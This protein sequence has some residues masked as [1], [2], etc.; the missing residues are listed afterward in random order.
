LSGIDHRSTKLPAMATAIRV[1]FLQPHDKTKPFTKH[2]FDM[3]SRLLVFALLASISL[4][5][6][7]NEEEA[8]PYFPVEEETGLVTYT[9]VIQVPGISNDS[10][11]NLAMKWIAV[12]YKMP[13]QVIRSQ[14]KEAG[15]IDIYHGFHIMR[16]EKNQTMKS[17]MIRYSCKLQFRDGRFKYTITKINL[18]GTTYFGIENWI[19][20]EK[21]LEDE[22]VPGYLTQIDA[23]MMELIASIESE[24]RPKAVKE[25]DDW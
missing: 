2:K 15:V 4:S 16:T 18:D 12:Y 24:I 25:E 17:G 13:G 10:L 19:N 1:L 23:F 7:K 20:D 11:Y 5:A 9:D 8:L 21:Y 22:H 3:K 14:D 6:Q